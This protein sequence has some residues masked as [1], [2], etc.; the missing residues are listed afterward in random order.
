MQG[1]MVSED[2]LQI[3]HSRRAGVLLREARESLIGETQLTVYEYSLQLDRCCA[4]ALSSSTDGAGL[5]F[6]GRLSGE[7]P[8]RG[9]RVRFADATLPDLRRSDPRSR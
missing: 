8:L 4:A 9:T 5:A 1:Q 6:A 7:N 2:R 3:L